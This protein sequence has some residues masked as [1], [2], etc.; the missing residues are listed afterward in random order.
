MAELQYNKNIFPN[1][2][3]ISF[4]GTTYSYN[5]ILIASKLN[6]KNGQ[7]YRLLDAIDIDWNGAWVSS[8]NTYLNSTEDL[9]QALND[10]NANSGVDELNK[11][12]ERVWNNEN[13]TYDADMVFLSTTFI[14]NFSDLNY[15]MR[16]LNLFPDA[17]TKQ[18]YYSNSNN[19]VVI[20]LPKETIKKNK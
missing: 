19:S 11:D 6:Q 8:L 15:R 7:G 1:V 4:D 12:L 2:N 10:L 14:C 18:I 20:I 5:G 9:V 13:I 3:K 16:V 17:V